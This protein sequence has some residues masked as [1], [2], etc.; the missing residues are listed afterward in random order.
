MADLRGAGRRGPRRRRA[1]GRRRHS[2]TPYLCRPIEHGA[3]I[4]V[5][6]ATKFIG[7]HGTTIAGVV[8]EAGT[9]DWGNG[10]FPH[11][12]RAGAR[13][14]AASAGGTTSAST[15]SSPSCAASSCA[16]SAR[17]LSPVQRLPAAAGLETLPLRMEAHVANAQRV[18]EWLEADPR[19][20]WVRYAGLPVAPAPRAGAQ[21]YLP[22]GPG[23]VFTLRRARAA[24]RRAGV[25]RVASSCAATWPTSAT[26]A[27]W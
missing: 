19:V 15:A 22:K 1:A 13:R 17:A 7:G 23:A 14:T 6:S 8:V 3:D 18:A 16:T 5:H 26:R 2:A 10:R 12:D 27:R 25:H 21:R 11:D 4:V 24:G 9:F 20:E